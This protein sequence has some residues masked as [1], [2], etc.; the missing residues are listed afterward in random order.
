MPFY[1]I[2][3][4]PRTGKYHRVSTTGLQGLKATLCGQEVTKEWTH[5]RKHGID[6][7]PTR[8]ICRRCWWGY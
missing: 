8:W 4:H 6:G 5:V 3:R 2:V 1:A 7:V